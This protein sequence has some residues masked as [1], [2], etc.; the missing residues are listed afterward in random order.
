MIKANFCVTLALKTE[1]LSNNYVD[2]PLCMLY[3]PKD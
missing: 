1:G 2:S 3:T